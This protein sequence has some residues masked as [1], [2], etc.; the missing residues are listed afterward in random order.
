MKKKAIGILA[1]IAAVALAATACAACGG[2]DT[3]EA[4]AGVIY[5]TDVVSFWVGVGHAYMTFEEVAEDSGEELTGYV[6]K[7]NVNSGDGY[8][9]W[10]YGSWELS[11]DETTLTL[12][13]TWEDGDTALAD[14][15]SGQDKTYTASSR[16]FTIPVDLPSASGTKFTLDLDNDKVGDGITKTPGTDDNNDN[17]KDGSGTETTVQSTLTAVSGTMSAKLELYSDSTWCISLCYYEGGDY[18]PSI[19]GTWALDASYNMVLTVTSDVAS[20]CSEATYTLTVDYKT[21]QYSGTITLTTY[22]GSAEFEFSAVSEEEEA[23]TPSVT[24]SATNDSVTAYI[25]IYE[26]NTWDLAISYYNGMEPVTSVSGTW[27]YSD[28]QNYNFSIV[29]TVT[30]DTASIWSSDSTYTLSLNSESGYTYSGTISLKVPTAQTAAEYSFSQV[31]DAT[32]EE[33]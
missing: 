15:T 6:F 11:S 22:S 29:L 26:N 27:A 2:G 9:T 25:Y 7:V 13:A 23:L 8:D 28:A 30:S 21:Y 33:G 18:T 16:K 14:A 5:Q 3:P 24:L 10:L 32:A 20:M 17:D 1:G 19:Y 31:V 12:N 4:A